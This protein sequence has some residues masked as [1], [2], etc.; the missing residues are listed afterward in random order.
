MYSLEPE[1]GSKR[2]SLST[3]QKSGEGWGLTH[4][5]QADQSGG[6]QRSLDA[7]GAN[8]CLDQVKG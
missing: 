3:L 5:Q 1:R 2:P 7:D 4:G 8:A 6:R